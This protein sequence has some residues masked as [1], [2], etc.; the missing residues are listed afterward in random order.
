MSREPVAVTAGPA[1]DPAGRAPAGRPAGA[2]S[3][4]VVRPGRRRADRRRLLEIALFAGPAVLVYV[5]F[6][7]VPI[8]LAAYYSVFRW[9]GLEPLTDFVGLDNYVRAFTDPVFLG[10]LGHNAFF[11]VMSLVV[12]LPVALAV[13]LLLNRKMRGRTAFRT[14]VFIPYVLSEVI[15]GVTWLLILQPDG[16]MDRVLEGVGLGGLVQLWLADRTVVLWT[17]LAVIS[18][19]YIGLAIILFLAGLQGVPEELHEAA[20]IDGA[21]WWQVQRRI[22]LPLLGPTIRIWM[23]LSIIGS[24]QLF[25]MVWVMTGGGPANASNTM[26]TYMIDR[27]FRRSQFGYGSAVAVILFVVSLVAAVFYQRFVLR[28]DTEGA[29]TGKGHRR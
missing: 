15:A 28:R 17:V 21:S 8:G 4:P 12:Q 13:A 2:P 3:R 1:A 23:F 7:L 18:W 10:A 11:V 14:I 22:T 16:L 5:L 6:V 24:L 27:G 29:L 19:K 25:D 26:A 20:S 9:N